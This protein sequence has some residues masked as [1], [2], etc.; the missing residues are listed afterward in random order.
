MEKAFSL[1]KNKEISAGSTAYRQNL[2]EQMVCP[3]CYEPVFKKK[4]WVASKYSETHFFSHYVGDQDSCP[5]R[6]SGEG[7][8]ENNKDSI[9]QLQ[10]LDIFNQYFR[11]NIKESLRK[12]VGIQNFNKLDSALEY[13]ER[14]CVQDINN[15]ELTKLELSL[16][17][18][19]DQ[20]ITYSID[21][22]L[23]ELEQALIPIYYH[24][25]SNYGQKNLKFLTCCSLLHTFY[26]ENV[27]LELILGKKVLKA[28]PELDS[29]L[30]GSAVLLLANSKYILWTGSSKPILHF[31]FSLSEDLTIKSTTINK[32]KK[33]KIDSNKSYSG[34]FSC[35]S[36]KKRWWLKSNRQYECY[37]CK[38]I[39]STGIDKKIT[40]TIDKKITPEISSNYSHEALSKKSWHYCSRCIKSYL[41]FVDTDCPHIENPFTKSRNKEVDS[42]PKTLQH[43]SRCSA[44]F[45]GA[46]STRCPYCNDLTLK[47]Y[48]SCESCG[49]QQIKEA[50]LPSSAGSNWKKCNF[51]NQHF[52]L[53]S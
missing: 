35:P 32:E 37:Y 31:I 50:L 44:N 45:I 46:H 17:K 18:S 25:K 3:T 20:P 10:K 38:S 43:C 52:Y 39:F 41:S 30:L 49:R 24:F 2:D 26:K 12:T 1:L 51:C 29:L 6:T 23:D 19:L 8:F 42:G 16:I 13:A 4:L 22:N 48:R 28:K 47:R 14:I 21:E 40:S 5:D 7:C 53:A 33:I 34:Y 36:C 9:S 27:H 11:E 15:K